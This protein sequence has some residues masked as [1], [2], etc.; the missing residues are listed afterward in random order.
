MTILLI[1]QILYSN[2]L[3]L[4]YFVHDEYMPEILVYCYDGKCNKMFS[5]F[6]NVFCTFTLMM[7][8]TV[9]SYDGKI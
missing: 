9:H 2:K 8:L 3:L 5:K 4:M 6:K 1:N 7:N